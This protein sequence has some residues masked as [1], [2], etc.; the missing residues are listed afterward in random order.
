MTLK[1]GVGQR[2]IRKQNIR[3]KRMKMNGLRMNVSRSLFK[4]A[5]FRSTKPFVPPV[6]YATP[7]PARFSR[8][9]PDPRPVMLVVVPAGGV[10]SLS[11]RALY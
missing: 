1:P 6:T 2:N 4:K 9:L 10:L 3:Q 5:S 7:F 8:I 11:S